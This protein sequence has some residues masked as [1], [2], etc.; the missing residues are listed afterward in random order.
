MMFDVHF[1]GFSVAVSLYQTNFNYEIINLL[2]WLYYQNKM[3]KLCRT[4]IHTRELITMTFGLIRGDD[5]PPL[6]D[7]I[8][9]VIY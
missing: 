3:Q 5:L 8:L 4:K 6:Y 9:S 2:I 7:G 1:N